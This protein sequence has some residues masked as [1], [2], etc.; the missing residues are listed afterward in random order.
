MAPRV[1]SHAQG[2]A[3][4]ELIL[5]GNHAGHVPMTSNV[6]QES[7][8]SDTTVPHLRCCLFSGDSDCPRKKTCY[9]PCIADLATLEALCTPF[10][11]LVP[12]PPLRVL[13]FSGCFRCFW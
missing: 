12:A 5:Q 13:Y 1:L 4:A 11:S 2:A 3:K 7:T 6:M 9:A 10:T 8:V